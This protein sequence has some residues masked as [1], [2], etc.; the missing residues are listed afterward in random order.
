MKPPLLI[1]QEKVWSRIA[2]LQCMGRGIRLAQPIDEMSIGLPIRL[3]E[4]CH[5]FAANLIEGFCCIV[6][7]CLGRSSETPAASSRSY[8]EGVSP[9][10]IRLL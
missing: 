1:R 10:S 2:N 6:R 4:L 9:E 7:H 5:E 8:V 3:L